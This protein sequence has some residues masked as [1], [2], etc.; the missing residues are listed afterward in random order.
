MIDFEPSEDQRLMQDSVA[1]FAKATLAPRAREFERLRAV[2]DDVRLLAHEMGLGL[3]AIPESAGGSG[4]GLTT[5]VLLEEELGSGAAS[6][7]R[8]YLDV[9]DPVNSAA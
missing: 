2:P 1:T 9:I 4:L 8:R 3:I 5:A 6:S 7:K